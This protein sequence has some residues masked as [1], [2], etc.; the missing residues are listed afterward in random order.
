MLNDEPFILAKSRNCKVKVA[1][2]K[3]NIELVAIKEF[4]FSDIE[5]HTIKK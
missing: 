2:S 3:Q 5:Q 1:V 4:F